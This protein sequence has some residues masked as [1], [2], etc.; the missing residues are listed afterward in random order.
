MSFRVWGC[1]RSGGGGSVGLREV[2]EHRG[3]VHLAP[4]RLESTFERGANPTLR[5]WLA[6][7]FEE[8]R[9]ISA[10]LVGGCEGDIVDSRLYRGQ[11]HRRE[12]G[13]S[14]GQR[15]DEAVQLSKREGAVD[16]AVPLGEVGIVV[17]PAHQHF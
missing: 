5:G 17:L 1:R 16:P 11:A 7:G 3:Q 2:A 15:T 12:S 6:E 13:E 8:G 9:R 4:S 10:E 14:V